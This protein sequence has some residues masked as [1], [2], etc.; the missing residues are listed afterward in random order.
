MTPACRAFRI[1]LEQQL[2]GRPDPASLTA[3]SW[4]EHLLGCNACR[5]FFDGE[6]ALEALLATLPDARL[7]PEI[8]RRVLVALAK[9]KAED[10]A[11]DVLLER[12]AEVEASPGL[13][14]QVL[15]RLDGERRMARASA[16]DVDRLDPLLDANGVVVPRDLARRT[17]DR[18]ASQRAAA[19]STSTVRDAGGDAR[20]DALLDRA[21][22]VV[23]PR[24]LGRHVLDGLSRHRTATPRRAFTLVRSSWAYAAA[25]LL[26]ASLLVWVFLRQGEP[27]V[28]PQLV[29]GTNP[30]TGVGT[31]DAEVATAPD[32][33]MLAALDVLENW[34]LLMVNDVDVLL[35]T[36]EPADEVL[37]DYQDEG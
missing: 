5:Q 29:N 23:I 26:V 9:S 12:D 11:L 32:A 18:L 19:F 16:G 31:N 33:Q 28:K 14:R 21:A 6:E 2:V 3:L 4:H 10:I 27:A 1:L 15:A 37:L 36:I 30:R 24:A 8:K 34:D 25:A 7:A 17:L 20:L 13:A 35:S 22:P